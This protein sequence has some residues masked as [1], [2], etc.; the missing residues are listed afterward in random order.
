MKCKKKCSLYLHHKYK[1]E[2]YKTMIR[3]KDITRIKIHSFSSIFSCFLATP[4]FFFYEI[5]HFFGRGIFLH[6]NICFKVELGMSGS[7]GEGYLLGDLRPI[8]TVCQ[9]PSLGPFSPFVSSSSFL[10]IQEVTKKTEG[11]YTHLNIE[12]FYDEPRNQ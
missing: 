4:R 9:R 1:D 10:P 12:V 3:L 6:P 8:E 11:K 7:T 5:H 2:E